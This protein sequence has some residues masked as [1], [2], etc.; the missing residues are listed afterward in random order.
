M[1]K[2]TL[3]KKHELALAG[4]ALGLWL[5]RWPLVQLIAWVCMIARYS[6]DHGIV[7]GAEMTFNGE[8]PC[9]LCYMARVGA[10]SDLA[11]LDSPLG[12][13]LLI[14]GTASVAFASIV[15]RHLIRCADD[16]Y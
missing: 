4:T 16:G 15:S 10:T 3:I 6:I 2:P 11:S 14:L 8:Y 1:N 12:I 9:G 7:R 13:S 5:L